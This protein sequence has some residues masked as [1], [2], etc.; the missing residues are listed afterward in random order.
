MCGVR[1]RLTGISNHFHLGSTMSAD[2]IQ[3]SPFVAVS[4][5]SACPARLPSPRP[6]G[7]S[8]FVVAIRPQLRR[9]AAWY[10]SHNKERHGIELSLPPYDGQQVSHL[11]PMIHS[12]DQIH[13]VQPDKAYSLEQ[14]R[15]VHKLRGV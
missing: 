2:D 14:S 15:N 4:S 1:V 9:A 12:R 5:L 6:S 3:G 8:G 10:S 7:S 11:R 13:F